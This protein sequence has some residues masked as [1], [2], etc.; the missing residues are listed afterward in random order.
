MNSRTNEAL[1]LAIEIHGAQF[2]KGTE[3]T[4][5]MVTPYITHLTAVAELVLRYGGDEEQM[6]AALLHDA[7]EDGGEHW[8]VRIEAFG[9]RVL[10][11]V[12]ACTDGVPDASGE[13]APWKERK[14]AYIRHVREDAEPDALLVSASDKLHNLSCIRWDVDE[15]G[16]RVFERFTAPPDETMWYYR[17]LIEAF[18][19]RGVPSQLVERLNG[20]Y[21]NVEDAL[22]RWKDGRRT[23]GIS[24]A[25]L[26]K[27]REKIHEND[28]SRRPAADSDSDGGATVAGR[29][30]R[31]GGNAAD[32]GGSAA[33]GAA[34]AGSVG[35][36]ADGG[37]VRPSGV[38]V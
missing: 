25:H 32:R 26:K 23:T 31:T 21:A 36:H 35:A 15:L 8:A 16:M 2:R 29:S 22:R 14:L 20:E 18:R 11:I 33:R 37:R 13:K 6:I 3:R 9:A 19:A 38:V 4:Q 12:R 7:L 1:A 5:K 10:S 27:E 30:E 24:N 34:A 17:A 28:S